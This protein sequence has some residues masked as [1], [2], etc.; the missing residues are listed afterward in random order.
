MIRWIAVFIL[1]FVL[2]YILPD[3]FI[4]KDRLVVELLIRT[5]MTLFFVFLIWVM[6]PNPKPK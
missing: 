6:K 4:S 2:T 1:G 5:M 3:D